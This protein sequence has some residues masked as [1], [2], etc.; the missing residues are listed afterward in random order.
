MVNNSIGIQYNVNYQVPIK[1]VTKGE[2]ITVKYVDIDGK[3]LSPDITLS[4][5]IGEAYATEEVSIDGY[6]LKEVEGNTTGTFSDTAQEVVY[7]YCT[8]SHNPKNNGNSNNHLPKTGEQTYGQ[9]IMTT[10]GALLVTLTFVVGKNAK[11]VIIK[12]IEC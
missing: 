12:K 11:K 5:N 2:D 4:G 10:V 6:M 9:V 3:T 7:V 1:Y 8:K